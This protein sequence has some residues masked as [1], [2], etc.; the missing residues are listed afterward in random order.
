[1]CYL[2]QGLAQ[3][4]TCWLGYPLTSKLVSQ[5]L[6]IGVS[7]FSLLATVKR[8]LM[9]SCTSSSLLST[10]RCSI[11]SVLLVTFAYLLQVGYVTVP[12]AIKPQ[13][14]SQ[15]RSGVPPNIPY[16]HIETQRLAPGSYRTDARDQ[17]V[18]NSPPLREGNTTTRNTVVIVSNWSR[19][20]NVRRILSL[21]SPELDSFM[22]RVLVWNNNPKP[23]A[24]L[25]SD[26][27]AL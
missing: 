16:H 15:V 7:V 26:I 25:V 19:F 1:M 14:R 20:P 22:K 24:Y 3:V 27:T 11:L 23:L 4:Y 10:A 2:Q 6:A 12:L 17:F 13:L 8:N 5:L 9:S 21:C 18:K